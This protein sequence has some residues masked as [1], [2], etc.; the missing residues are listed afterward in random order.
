MTRPVELKQAGCNS[1]RSPLDFIPGRYN[2]NCN[3]SLNRTNI[4]I[5]HLER[6]KLDPTG[7]HGNNYAKAAAV[8]LFNVL[9]QEKTSSC[10]AFL[11]WNTFWLRLQLKGAQTCA[12]CYTDNGN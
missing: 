6:G 3:L 1:D 8:G 4:C 11:N 10:S 2:R 12:A 9:Q 5:I 7:P